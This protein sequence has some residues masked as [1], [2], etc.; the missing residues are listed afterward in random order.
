[1]DTLTAFGLSRL[2]R[3]WSATRFILVGSMRLEALSNDCAPSPLLGYGTPAIYEIAST[4]SYTCPVCASRLVRRHESPCVGMVDRGRHG[5]G[6][7][8]RH[9]PHGS[10]EIRR[11]PKIS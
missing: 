9:S 11:K 2:A 5:R 1:M 4:A 3:C 7:W 6:K 10:P 8:G